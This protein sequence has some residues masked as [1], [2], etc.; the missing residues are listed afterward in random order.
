MYPY[1]QSGD[2]LLVDP[3]FLPKKGDLVLA[4]LDGEYLV[5]RYLGKEKIKGDKNKFFDA[6]SFAIAGTVIGRTDSSKK[7]VIL[8]PRRTYGIVRRAQ[9]F[10][11]SLNRRDNPR[12]RWVS[13][14]LMLMNKFLRFTEDLWIRRRPV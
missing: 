3:Y 13:G 6:R 5:H 9:A 7:R 10:L 1:L 14:A 8:Y 4:S 11:C 2:K 12:N